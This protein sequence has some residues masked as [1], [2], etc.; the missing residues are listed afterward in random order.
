[1]WGGAGG[2][3]RQLGTMD[4]VPTLSTGWL[5]QLW[6]QLQVGGREMAPEKTL[7]QSGEWDR[8]GGFGTRAYLRLGLRQIEVRR[9]EVS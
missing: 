9:D 2:W 4:L 5:G 1:V 8:F 6:R 3:R 7:G